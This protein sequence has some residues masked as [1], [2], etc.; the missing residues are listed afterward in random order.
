MLVVGLG[1]ATPSFALDKQ[2]SAH[3]GQVIGPDHGFGIS[4]SV[5]AGVAPFNPSYAARPDNSGLALGRVAPHFDIDLIGARLSLPIDI[6]V[7]TDR[8]RS[9]VAKL[10]PSEL[11]V[12]GG[13]TSTWQLGPSA[14]ET[15]ARIEHD[16]PVD[17]GRYNQSYADL[18]IRWL[19][20]LAAID[21]RLASWLHGG[22]LT[23]QLTL[24]WFGY[25]PSYAARPDNTG[26]ALLRY[27]FHMGLSAFAGR[28]LAS[29]DAMTF[30]D[31][32]R[33]GFR[34]S[35]LDLTADLGTRLAPVDIHVAYER[36]MPID[37]GGLVQHFVTV[38]ATLAFDLVPHPPTP[39]VNTKSTPVAH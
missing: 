30:T 21:R 4:G 26:L 27:G 23:G 17:R 38:Y 7:W 18:R 16:M 37:Q 15:G 39:S 28:I 31:R 8:T 34:P 2:G 32:R 36:D 25:N 35:E 19:G 1:L 3:A 13:V 12:I 22:D 11:D 29:V 20:S 10:G 6:N 33:H 24:G 14:L 9:G 5:L